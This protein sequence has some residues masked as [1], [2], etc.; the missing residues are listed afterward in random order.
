[1]STK[2]NHI[3][4]KHLHKR[5]KTRKNSKFKT[6]K[7]SPSRN[8]NKDRYSC[9]NSES[10][11]K[12]RNA[13]NKRHPDAVIN[14][15]SPIEIWGSLKELNSKSCSNEMCW[16]KQQCIKHD[17]D[18]NLVLENFAPLVPK[19]WFKK[20]NE[21]LSSIEI[22]QVMKQWEKKYSNFLFLGPSPIDYD[23]P[24]LY[25]ECVWEDLCKFSLLNCIKK[26]K[27][28]I[29]IIFNTDPHTE[30]GEHWVCCFIDAVKERVYYFDSYGDRIPTRIRKFVR[31]VEKQSE[32]IGDKYE[33]KFN[34]R[35]H[36]YSMS[37]CGMYCLYVIIELLK[38]S[39]WEKVSE[40]KI[41][42]KYM[43]K[44]RKIYFNHIKI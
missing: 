20:K 23:K 21:W 17:L 8:K 13:W 27:T 35:R 36:Q 9:Y 24:L 14:T 4:K 11:Y 31:T 42:D 43:K 30:D 6:L 10:L 28:K 12:I 44:L 40:K 15:N 37:E 22:M 18:K 7:C 34:K 2:K 39:P 5:K 32:K 3:H 16:I 29:G 25:G 19:E 1:M 33:Y 41:N 38:G 26:G